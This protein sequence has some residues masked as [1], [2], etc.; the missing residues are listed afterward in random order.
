MY[1]RKPF[2]KL[3]GIS[4]SFAG[5]HALQDVDMTIYEGE[6]RCLAGENGGGKSTLI[7]VISG[8]Y[9]PDKGEIE[10][11]GKVFHKLTPLQAI[12]EG[13]QIIYQDFSI[14]PNLTV[15]ENIG[16][17]WKGCTAKSWWIGRPSRRTRSGRWI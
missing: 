10:I 7:K 13:I 8:F 2:I 17:A 3:T 9:T 14:F 15:A 11:A 16:S 6:I 4:K 12:H 5:V 1:M